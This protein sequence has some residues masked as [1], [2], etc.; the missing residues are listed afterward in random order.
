MEPEGSP[1]SRERGYCPCCGYRT[2]PPDRP[3]SYEICPVCDWMDDPVQ[4]H[5]PEYVGD[6]NHVS[7]A[8]ARANVAEHGACTPGAAPDTRDPRDDED[9]DPNWPYTDRE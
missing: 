2:L 9:R 1:V 5:D 8:E 3:G 7:L 4:F 6:T